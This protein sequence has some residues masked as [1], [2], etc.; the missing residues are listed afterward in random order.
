M[1]KSKWLIRLNR[2]GDASLAR[3]LNDH[4]TGYLGILILFLIV[5]RFVQE[6]ILQGRENSQTD[7][8]KNVYDLDLEELEAFRKQH[9]NH[10]FLAYLQLE[11]ENR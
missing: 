3:N 8:D 5:A 9:S 6:K 7:I 11:E 2:R 10:P 1:F 4:F